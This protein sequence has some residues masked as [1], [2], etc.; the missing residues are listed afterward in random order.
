[1]L[2]TLFNL[3]AFEVGW[4]ACVLGGSLI[5]GLVVSVIIAVHLIWLAY[6]GEW[7]W[8]VGFALLGLIVDGGLTLIGGFT[9]ANPHWWP[10]PL[11]PW[12][13]A[14]W[15]LFAT[16]LLHSL[17]WLWRYPVLAMLCGAISGPLSYLGGAELAEITLAPWLLPAQAV[18]WAL[19][20][21]WLCHRLKHRV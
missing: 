9:F 8:I 17:T 12:L 7:R 3:I 14:L 20:C 19:L 18:I 21:L 5:G 1:M 6:P 15:P 16:L 13:W 2:L 10:L 4:L 11:P